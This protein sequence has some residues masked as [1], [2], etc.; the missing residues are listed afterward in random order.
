MATVFTRILDGDIPGD[1]VWRDDQCAVFLS[2][3]PIETG[4]ALVVPIEEVD[5][6]IDCSPG[7]VARLFEV[8]HHIGRA[9]QAAFGCE[10]VGLIV[11]GYEVPHTHVHV[12]PTNDMSGLSFAR[13]ASSVSPEALHVAAEAIRTE[14]R[15][16]GR[17]EV[18]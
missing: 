6:W 8:A 17:P 9:Q 18:V 16:A 5:H 1:F 7:L 12:I 4:H 14:L 2:I 10:R 13:A 11:A 15:R 3:N